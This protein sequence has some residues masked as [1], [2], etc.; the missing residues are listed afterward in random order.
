MARR[1]EGRTE[2]VFVRLT[3]EEAAAVAEAA[4]RASV[5]GGVWARR[6]LV[7]AAAQA[8]AVWQRV[9]AQANG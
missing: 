2:V 3:P 4:R 7:N 9:D 1:Y 6:L 5:T 8:A